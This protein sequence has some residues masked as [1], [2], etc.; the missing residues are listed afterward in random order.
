MQ[1]RECAGT[2]ALASGEHEHALDIGLQ[3]M[4]GRKQPQREVRTS[5]AR[6]KSIGAKD[7]H[8]LPTPNGC[9]RV[10][11]DDAGVQRRANRPPA[12]CRNRLVKDGDH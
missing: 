9:E 2:L 3:C 8:A 6:G 5:T 4:L 11:C 1:R 7:D 12:S 10:D